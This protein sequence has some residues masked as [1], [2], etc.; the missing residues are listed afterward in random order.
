MALADLLVVNKIDLAP[1]VGADVDLMFREADRSPARR[2]RPPD[3]ARRARRRGRGG[4]LAPCAVVPVARHGVRAHAT[5]AVARRDGRDELVDRRS[6]APFSVRRCGDRIMIA[7]SAA[8]PVGGDELELSITVDEGAR[9]A[10]GSVAATMVWPGAN[11]ER[12][13]MSTVATVAAGGRL[14]LVGRTHRVGG[15]VVAPRRHDRSARGVGD[16]PR[17]RGGGAGPHR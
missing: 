10:I 2:A 16:V 11:G 5:I 7:S 8:M 3:V 17:G 12:S 6:Q 15:G 4:R 9:A 14:D 1:Y 13:T